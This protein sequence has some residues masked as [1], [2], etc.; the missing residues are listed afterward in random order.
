MALNLE[1]QFAT[2]P[3]A[4]ALPK[5]AWVPDVLEAIF[6]R[7]ERSCVP[8]ARMETA[9]SPRCPA[10]E[11]AEKDRCG[12]NPGPGDSRP[13]A[14]TREETAGIG[15]SVGAGSMPVWAK[16]NLINSLLSAGTRAY[17]GGARQA[18]PGGGTLRRARLGSSL[19]PGAG[20][21]SDR[22]T[23]RASPARGR[24]PARRRAARASPRRTPPARRR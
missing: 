17:W 7:Q 24:R 13:W 4:A 20:R 23:R 12:D 6:R 19:S 18:P 14:T 15:R 16:L 8:P 9:R 10:C 21:P 3:E 5:A 2:E 1:V 11:K 22:R